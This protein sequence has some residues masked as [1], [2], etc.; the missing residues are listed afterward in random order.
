MW[1]KFRINNTISKILCTT[2]ATTK[3]HLLIQ[4]RRQSTCEK[5]LEG[6]PCDRCKEDVCAYSATK[7]KKGLFGGLLGKNQPEETVQPSKQQCKIEMGKH[8][9]SDFT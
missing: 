6:K 8:W 7:K 3:N 9:P 2:T 4:N 5:Q 1:Q